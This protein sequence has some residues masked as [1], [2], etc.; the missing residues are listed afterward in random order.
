[1]SKLFND[2]DIVL[3]DTDDL[4]DLPTDKPRPQTRSKRKWREIEHL[5]ERKRLTSEI[6]SYELENYDLSS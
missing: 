6:N 4:L 1:M 5:K 2:D 3:T